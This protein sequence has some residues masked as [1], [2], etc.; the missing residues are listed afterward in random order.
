MRTARPGLEVD[1]SGGDFC[2]QSR[3][4]RARFAEAA[5]GDE[6]DGVGNAP[7][8]LH[9]GNNALAIGDGI[10]DAEFLQAEH[11][12]AHAEDLARAEVPVGDGGEI[13]V[14]SESL[15]RSKSSSSFLRGGPGMRLASFHE[16]EDS[17]DQ[18]QRGEG[19]IADNGHAV[20]LLGLCR[21]SRS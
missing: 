12:Q 21:S 7:V 20:E 8:D 19:A 6:R 2:P 11:G 14:F 13:E 16:R 1:E 9:V 15:H 17:H 5:V 10:V 4:F 3:N 18:R